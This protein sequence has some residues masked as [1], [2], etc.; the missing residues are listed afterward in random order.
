[1]K[2]KQ[3]KEADFRAITAA[4]RT[5]FGEPEVLHQVSPLSRCDSAL[6]VLLATILTQATNDRNAMQAWLRFKARF[7]EPHDVRFLS[8]EELAAVIRPAGLNIQKALVFHKVLTAISQEDSACLFATLKMNPEQAWKFLIALPGVGPKTAACTM[9]FGLG[10][11]AFPVDLHINRIAQR[12]GWVSLQSPPERTQ[13]ELTRLIPPVLFKD[14]HIL[15]LELGRRFC[16]PRQPRCGEC[17]LRCSCSCPAA[18]EG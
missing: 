15:L 13:A 18:L 4:L 7:P 17:P 2:Q 12:M 9:L 8:T 10:L 5:A 14:M 1:M 6:E 11:P 16:R 3:L